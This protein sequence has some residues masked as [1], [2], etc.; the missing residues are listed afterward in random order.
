LI[1]GVMVAA[2]LGPITA[3]LLAV[4]ASGHHVTP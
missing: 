2:L 3:A 4:V 1:L